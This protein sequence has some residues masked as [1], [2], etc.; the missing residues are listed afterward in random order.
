MESKAYQDVRIEFKKGVNGPDDTVAEVGEREGK[1]H[2]LHTPCSNDL[3][4]KKS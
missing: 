2:V 4:L 3:S 1:W